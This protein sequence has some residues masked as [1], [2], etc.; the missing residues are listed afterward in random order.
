MPNRALLKGGFNLV[1]KML[2]ISCLS[3]DSEND[4]NDCYNKQ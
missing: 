3:E 2:L 1:I 4:L